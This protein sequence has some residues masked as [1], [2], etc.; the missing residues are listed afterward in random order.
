MGLRAKS[1]IRD[2]TNRSAVTGMGC[3][4]W[5]GFENGAPRVIFEYKREQVTRGWRG[6]CAMRS[7]MVLYCSMHIIMAKNLMMIRRQCM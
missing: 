7:F 6:K 4:T 5:G 1:W 2:K 3:E